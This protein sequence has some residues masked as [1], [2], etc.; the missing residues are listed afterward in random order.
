[1]SLTRGWLSRRRAIVL[2]GMAVA[3]A[4]G[5][6]AYHRNARDGFLR[7]LE[8]VLPMSTELSANVLRDWVAM[9]ASQA[10]VLAKLATQVRWADSRPDATL[11]H[12]M[13]VMVKSGG[14]YSAHVIE[15]MGTQE[16][17]RLRT[18]GDSLSLIEFLAPIGNV[19][20]AHQWIVLSAV[21]NESAFSQFNVAAAT[22]RSQRTTLLWVDGDSVAVVTASSAGG[23]PNPAD[24][25]QTRPKLHDTYRRAVIAHAAKPSAGIDTGLFGRRVVFARAPVPGTPW[26]LV[27][28]RDVDELTQLISTSLLITDAIFALLALLSIGV[29]AMLWRSA[30]LRRESDAMQLRSAF[31]SSVSHELRTPLTQ[32]RMYAEMLRL[33]LMDAPNESARALGVIEKEAE[34]LSMLVERSL[35]FVRSGQMPP[36][37]EPSVVDVATAVEAAVSVVTPLGAERQAQFVVD[38]MEGVSARIERD[39]LHQVM[40]NLFDN[41]IKYGP[42]GQTIRVFATTEG[43]VTRVIVEDEGPGIPR[44]EREIIWQAFAR[45]RVAQEQPQL[46]SGI[47]LAVVRDLVTRAEGRAYVEARPNGA[48]GA[49]FIVEL[50]SGS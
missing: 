34:R 43:E 38:V 7:Q 37:P 39:S 26:L 20:T 18:V 24:A 13:R 49:R 1:M 25:A 10:D 41:A 31:I 12:A 19:A 28:E 16:R 48:V 45:G 32:I 44:E 6:A 33:G 17:L 21:A 30:F 11:S 35:S 40:L 29:V 46:G 4:I 15:A 14:F 23:T 22:D 42:S 50:P 36:T 47:G 3:S 9:R 8:A 27:R 5:I 2:G